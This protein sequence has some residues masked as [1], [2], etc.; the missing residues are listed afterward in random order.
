[1]AVTYAYSSSKPFDAAL[2]EIRRQ[3]YGFAPRML[4]FF[5]SSSYDLGSLAWGL[6]ALYPNAVALGCSTAGEIVSGRILSGSV[7][8]MAFDSDTIEDVAVAFVNVGNQHS[9]QMALDRIATRFGVSTQDIDYRTHFGIVLVDGLSMA[10]ER[11]MDSL[12]DLSDVTFVGGSAGDDMR[13]AATTV[14]AEGMAR[15]GAAVLAIVKPK[16]KFDFVKTQSF[17]VL[18]KRLVPTKVDSARREVQA[19][20]GRPAVQEYASYVGCAPSD[21]ASQ[22]T[23]YPLGL[24]EG[25]EPFVRSP[26]RAVGDS[27][28]FY[29]N[30][31]EGMELRLLESTDI[32]ADTKEAVEGARARGPVSAMINFDSVLRTQEL[33]RRGQLDDYG[34]I[35][36]KNPTIGF[37][38]YGEEY[39]GHVNQ[40]STMLVLR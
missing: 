19:I 6:E 27:L 38:T 18:P 31:N 21:V 4:V 7:A 20:N 28:F 39:I 22:F 5:A 10:E 29:G 34:R 17:R 25:G 3:L 36:A 12:G 26:R 24:V 8:V 37:S 30:V 15:S 1:M 23:R 14:C 32:L 13:F 33:Q 11:L 40:T 16:V 9:V 35:F 2:T